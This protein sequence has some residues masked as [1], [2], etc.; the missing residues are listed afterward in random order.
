MTNAKEVRDPVVLKE[1]GN[2]YYKKGQVS[3]L[4]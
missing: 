1:E 4:G 3:Q 2:E